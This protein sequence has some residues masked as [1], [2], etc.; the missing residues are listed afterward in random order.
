MRHTY[1][2]RAEV[3]ELTGDLVNGTPTLSW[4]KLTDVVDPLL[5]VAGELMCRL[6]LNFIRVG[7]DQ[8]MPV[9]AGRAPDRTGVMF[10]D[11]TDYVR[12]G[13]FIRAL[14]GP[15][16]GTFEIRTIPDPAVG[17]YNAHHMEV[18]VFEYA[19]VLTGV[20]PGTELEV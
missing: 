17:M 8:P 11:T 15:V 1:N 16:T 4:T 7:K 6:D 20:F 19:Q 5:G 3:L 10:F 14:D 18:Q 13:L 12:A 9:I 2:V